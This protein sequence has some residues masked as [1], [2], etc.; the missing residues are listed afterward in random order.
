MMATA[1]EP[2]TDWLDNLD[3]DELRTLTTPELV[4]EVEIIFKVR[5]QKRDLVTNA[6]TPPPKP[7]AFDVIGNELYLFLFSK[8][9][10][11]VGLESRYGQ[12]AK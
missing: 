9:A 2:E 10:A 8:N 12:N 5:L 4:K 7:S 1:P 6:E 3:P 11:C